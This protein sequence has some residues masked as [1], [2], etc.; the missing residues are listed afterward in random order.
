MKSNIWIKE[1][2]IYEL[3][4]GFSLN[5]ANPKEFSIFSAI[6]RNNNNWFRQSFN[7]LF[8]V[9][10]EEENCF[11]I[12]KDDKRVGGVILEP[13]MIGWV[14][15][16]PPFSDKHKI[17]SLIVLELRKWS[18]PNKNIYAHGVMTT[19]LEYYFRTGFR[20]TGE[21]R[22]I[23][24]G[25]NPDYSWDFS[26]VMIRPTEEYNITFE[27]DYITMDLK[28][29]NIKDLGH[30][31]YKS[32]NGD[33]K[34]ENFISSCEEYFN[35]CNDATLNASTVLLSKI[36]NEIVGACLISLWE[37]WP[38]IY[39][40]AVHPSYRGKGLAGRMIKGALNNLK[41]EY[42]VL[43]LFVELGNDVEAL[44]HNLGFIAGE[45][46]TSLYI[47]KRNN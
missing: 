45:E 39:D 15:L 2:V 13:N 7:K 3:E 47:P 38:N 37:E 10:S 12:L 32:Y 20:M 23:K 6:Y 40:V 24:E 29:V 19:E 5:K 35:Y 41:S 36:N 25:E 31:F 8:E 17:L 18:D 30:F 21:L 11:W 44:Y 43:R 1:K 9:F 4:D 42:P 16:I 28:E 14:F 33:K 46:T 22:N 27:E 26:R 34:K